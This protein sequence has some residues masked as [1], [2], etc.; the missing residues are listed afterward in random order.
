MRGK[1]PE[2]LSRERVVSRCD[3][4]IYG[5]CVGDWY[6]DDVQPLCLL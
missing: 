3:V 1:W 2:K 6:V 4:I 5:R